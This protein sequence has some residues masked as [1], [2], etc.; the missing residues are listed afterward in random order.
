MNE[1]APVKTEPLL[2]TLAPALLGLERQLHP[3]IHAS[4]RFPMSTLQK[5]SL[6][7][8]SADL[9]RQ[10]AALQLEKPLLVIVLM[11]GTGVGK[12]TLL[13]ALAGGAVAQASFA[14]PTTRDPVVYYHESLQTQRFDVALR[15]CKLVAHSRPTLEQKILVDTPDLDSNDLENRDKLMQMLP[16]ADIV[17]YVGSQEK[18]H[19]KLGWDLFLDQRQRRAFAFVLNKWDRCLHPGATGTRPDEDLISDLNAQG[20][21]NPMLFRTVAQFWVDHPE[22]IQENG[23]PPVE[24]EGFRELV[25]WLELGLTRLEVEAIKARGVTQML[26]QLQEALNAVRPPDLTQV[27]E[28]T[29]AAWKKWLGDEARANAVVLLSTLEPYQK[30]VE[31]YFAQ[32]RQGLFRGLMASYLYWFN[33]L[34]YVGSNLRDRMP[35]VPRLTNPVDKPAEWDLAAFTLA[36]SRSAADQHLDARNKALADRL[37]VEAKGQNFPVNLLGD[38]TEAASQLDWGNLNAQALV[39]V[40]GKIE[41][42]W[43]RPTG[44]KRIVQGTTIFLADWLPL[45]AG[46]STIVYM[47][48]IY[49]NVLPHPVVADDKL[50][51][52]QGL[53]GLLDVLLTPVGVVF[54]VLIVLHLLIS[55]IL[56]LRWQAIRAELEKHLEV[57]LRTELE[58]VYCQVPHDVAKQLLEEREE[59]D[60]LLGE[61][62]EVSGWLEKSEQTASIK[63][64][65]GRVG[66]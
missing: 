9:Q 51:P 63:E 42:V 64:L 28:R 50:G 33:R 26:H 20:F 25:N 48:L 6:E 56:P 2:R 10:A 49:S 66:K 43:T 53:Y 1:I 21:A 5:A 65:Y 34:R 29:S 16:V 37:L 3:W 44:L 4:H 54:L 39:E 36:A 7:G 18:Y 22:R 52:R 46:I 8:L 27:A 19:D 23:P 13:N 41:T 14:R 60:R 58:K 24:G 62:K 38:S 40:L 11:G 45:L 32:E 31:H 55:L 35:F 30:E 61:V 12:S 47:A 17:L 59:V 57:R 15:R